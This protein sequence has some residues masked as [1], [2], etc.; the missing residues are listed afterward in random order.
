M[1]FG[2]VKAKAR[3]TAIVSANGM[4]GSIH[5]FSSSSPRTTAGNC[6]AKSVASSSSDVPDSIPI[7][8]RT[9]AGAN[10]AVTNGFDL[11]VSYEAASAPKR[12]RRRDAL[13]GILG[14]VKQ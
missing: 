10:L 8:G 3:N 2:I 4:I 14:T 5:R 1:Y 7:H 6:D 11:S 12:E 13:L 9:F